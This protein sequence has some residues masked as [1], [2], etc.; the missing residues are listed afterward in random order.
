LLFLPEKEHGELLGLARLPVAKGGFRLGH[1]VKLRRGGRCAGAGGWNGL[2]RAFDN[3]S[4]NK[5]AAVQ[6]KARYKNETAEKNAAL[7]GVAQWFH[8]IPG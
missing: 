2:A 8:K 7:Y 1:G 3:G 5:S 4:F 6:R